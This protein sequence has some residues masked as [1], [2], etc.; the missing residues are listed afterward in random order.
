MY[1][2][3]FGAITANMIC[4]IVPGIIC[5]PMIKVLGNFFIPDKG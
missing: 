2:G 1:Y 3:T 5:G 4:L